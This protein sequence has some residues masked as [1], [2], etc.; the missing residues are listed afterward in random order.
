MKTSESQK[1]VHVVES[2]DY[3]SAGI[4]GDSINMGSVHRACFILSFGA[5]TGNSILSFY[6]GASAGTKTTQ[7]PFTYRRSSADY[8]AA[9]ADLFGSL[10]TVAA[11]GL[12]LTANTFDHNTVVVEIEN[13]QMTADEPWLTMDVDA[14]A[15]VML[16]G[17]VA[18]CD[19]RHQANVQPTVI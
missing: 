1:I 11:A 5:I 8:K 3:G 4:V 12:T 2:K 9:G 15:T 14:T 16:L 6:T 19:P 17:A 13:E 7:I 18:V 10:T